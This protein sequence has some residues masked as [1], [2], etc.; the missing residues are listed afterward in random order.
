MF[1][2]Q[3]MEG[4]TD[5]KDASEYFLLLRDSRVA[6]IAFTYRFGKVLKAVKRSNGGASDEMQRAGNVNKNKNSSSS[7]I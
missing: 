7:N 2:T 3:T 1:Y 6:T 4:V 5:F